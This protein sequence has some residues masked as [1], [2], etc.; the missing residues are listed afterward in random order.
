M[1]L[2]LV[3]PDTFEFRP[4]AL[5]VCRTIHL[6]GKPIGTIR[7]CSDLSQLHE[8]MRGYA[9]ALVAVLIAGLAASLIAVRSLERVLTGPVLALTQ[10]AR[11]ITDDKNFSA[12]AVKSSNDELGTLI[13]CFNGM[14][15]QIQQRDA[16]LTL[17]RDHL[18]EMVKNRTVELLRRPGPGRRGQPRQE[19]FPG[20]H[21]PR[22]PHTHDRHSGLCGFDALT[23]A[24]HVRPDQCAAG[25]SP[26]RPASDG[27]HQRH[28]R[29]QQ[30]RS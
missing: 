22:N 12:R 11:R 18:E 10:T 3:A 16:Q 7:I 23:G 1:D 17:H 26:Q 15:D 21:E 24:D 5:V 29:Y 9:L 2:H 14:L 8:R 28:S 30:N 4:D 20:Q 13:D 6:D 25:G 27:S 19:Q